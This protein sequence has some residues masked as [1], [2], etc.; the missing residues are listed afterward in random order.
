MTIEDIKQEPDVVMAMLG[1]ET[2]PG[3]LPRATKPHAIDHCDLMFCQ[4][5]DTHGHEIWINS[6]DD[7][8]EKTSG[9]SLPNKD[10]GTTWIASQGMHPG[11][12]HEKERPTLPRF[13][14]VDDGNEW[15]G[16]FKAGVMLNG[17]Q[18]KVGLPGRS[19][20]KP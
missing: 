17:G 3:E 6:F 15:K 16:A 10:P 7:Y 19:Q 13:T 14:R 11:T 1:K 20:T 8:T 4:S 12:R 5:E 18:L 9:L 2:E